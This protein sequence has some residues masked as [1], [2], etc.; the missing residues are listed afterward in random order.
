M[1]N[2]V[3]P[4]EVA[5]NDVIGDPVV[6]PR[7]TFGM[8]SGQDAAVVVLVGLFVVAFA[9][10]FLIDT[11]TPR[12]VLLATSLPFGL[13]SFTQLLRRGDGGALL[14]GSLI[15]WLVLGA[16]ISQQLRVTLVGVLGRESSV[17][18]VCAW[19]G[20]WAIGRGV[21]VRAR[22]RMQE[23]FL[24][25]MVLAVIVATA[26]VVAQP[27]AGSL[28]LVDGRP[29]GLFPNPVYFGG[30]AVGAFGVA[31]KWFI[32]QPNRILAIGVALFAFAVN[33]TGARSAGLSVALVL[34]VLSIGGGR[35]YP[36]RVGVAWGLAACG[37]VVSMLLVGLVGG[38]SAIERVESG[39]GGSRIDIWRYSLRAFQSN[40]MFGTGVGRFRPGVQQYFEPLFAGADPLNPWWDPHNVFAHVGVIGGAPAVVLVA[41]FSFVCARRCRG[42]LAVGAIAIAST[43]L[44]QAL[45]IPTVS[46]LMLMLGASWTDVRPPTARRLV[47]NRLAAIAGA[48][49][50]VF[51][52]WLAMTDL[53][54]QHSLRHGDGAAMERAARL[55][56]GDPLLWSFISAQY[57]NEAL[58]SDSERAGRRLTA[59][60]GDRV[61][62]WAARASQYIR[63]GQF[64]QAQRALARGAE[65]QRW[66]PSIATLQLR[67]GIETN[68]PAME[69][70]AL[71]DLCTMGYDTCEVTLADHDVAS[72]QP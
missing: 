64:E 5:S 7:P 67:L 50:L 31:S 18:I 44:L 26:Q 29:T 10:F 15:V 24:I 39:S 49:G 20:L 19:F 35:V 53:S 33:L 38:R 52:V 9:P 40:W 65:L 63:L 61:H 59:S 22:Q 3:K 13:I 14:A 25:S 23:V 11:W 70:A 41:A 56:P 1:S 21:E 16:V 37:V 54:F 30:V 46:L 58:I 66:S 28:A 42:P 69:T 48:G 57:T 17:L 62:W 2:L 34:V 51:G 36:R 8:S 47:N 6:R 55:A 12:A 45:V 4:V 71:E 72:P 32:D 43:L 27:S 60:E 68:D